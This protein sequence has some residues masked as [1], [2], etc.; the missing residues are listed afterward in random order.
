VNSNVVV[1]A[2]YQ[3]DISLQDY[4]Y[5]VTD[6][7]IAAGETLDGVKES[8]SLICQDEDFRVP[9]VSAERN[10]LNHIASWT[11]L[12]YAHSPEYIASASE[13][14]FDD[15]QPT[16]ATEEHAFFQVVGPF[17]AGNYTA[18]TKFLS[19]KSEWGAAS[20]FVCE[21]GLCMFVSPDMGAPKQIITGEYQA[22]AN[23]WEIHNVNSVYISCTISQ[24]AY[25]KIDGEALGAIAVESYKRAY[26][27]MTGGEWKDTVPTTDLGLCFTH[28][29]TVEFIFTAAT[30][31]Y[32]VGTRP[33][34]PADIAGM[35]ID[36]KQVK[37][38]QCD[39][40]EVDLTGSEP[41]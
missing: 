10:C 18:K 19:V 15:D 6:A 31:A 36:M 28:P 41:L 8:Y 11:N 27:K 34:A 35:D 13:L 3:A 9:V 23:T 38:D 2:G 1:P 12:R 32:V 26:E 16:T 30:A 5:T 29:H 4:I 17:P 14:S 39:L 37:L 7:D 40:F 33:F 21:T 20:A 24:I 25:I 22:A